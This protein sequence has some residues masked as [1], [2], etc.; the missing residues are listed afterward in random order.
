MFVVL[1]NK[2]IV[3]ALSCLVISSCT[4]WKAND[5]NAHKVEIEVLDESGN[6]IQG[7]NVEAVAR[8]DKQTDEKGRVTLY[9]IKTGLHIVT[10]Q[11]EG[12]LTKQVK[13]SIP[14]DAKKIVSFALKSK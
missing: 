14:A 10:V 2:I 13:I 5:W 12:K 7:A 8:H 6:V 1:K 11:H 9:F 3:L 4:L